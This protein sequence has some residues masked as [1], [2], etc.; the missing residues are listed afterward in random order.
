MEQKHRTS[1]TLSTSPR[2]LTLPGKILAVC[3][4]ILPF[5]TRSLTVEIPQA[6]RSAYFLGDG[7]YSDFE[8]L[9]REFFLL[10]I[11]AAGVIWFFYEQIA[12]RP[13]RK[14][15]MTR[16]TAV[17]FILLGL[18]L[19]LGLLST[20][21]SEYATESWLGIYMLYE[22]YLALVGY[23]VVFTA[24]WYW[25]DRKEVL[26]FVKS[27]LTVLSIVLGVL[28][29]L[30]R[31]GICYY[32]SAI[33]QFLGGLQGT[34]GV[35][36]AVSLTFGN[37][38]YLG[39]YCAMLLPVV[40]SLITREGTTKRLLVQI[41]AA[42][43]LATALLLSKVMNA[44]LL[45]FGLTVVFLLIWAF[46]TNW[47][48][49]V[50][51]CLC[52]V[53]AAAVVFGSVGFLWS[54]NGD[55]LSEKF[56]H[57]MIGMAQEETFR[58]LSIDLNGNTVSVKNANT[59]FSVATAGNNLT[60]QE[61]T[62]T[63]NGTEVT[64]QIDADGMTCS[65]AEPELKHCQVQVQSDRLDFLMGY[66]T[67]LEVVRQDGSWLAMG[68]GQTPLTEVPEVSSSKSLQQCYPYLNGRVFVW[69]NTISALRDCWIL[70]HGPATTIFYLNQYDLPALLNIFGVYALYNKPHNWYLQVAQDTGIPS[71]LLIL[72]V[73]VLFFVCGF[74]KC[75]RKQE[76]WD[77]FRTGLLLSVLSYA[78]M[79]FFNDSLIYHAPMFWF[80]L[81]IGWRQMTVGTE[82]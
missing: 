39:M 50:K 21:T 19:L 64:P 46:H 33:V 44:I 31:S 71:M 28:A 54:R 77:A 47:K 79:A 14:L 40:V 80:L 67:P 16:L 43:L 3:L 9:F 20:I 22:G 10:G 45:G 52:G 55:T 36:D 61:L 38:D 24:A 63:C 74:R 2:K 72:G 23:V 1:V 49:L 37:A 41:L 73:L 69:A 57:T 76:K 62:F 48:P 12:L 60:P 68:V 17:V 4:C 6:V 15:P 25:I 65:F 53:T 75:F 56:R 51:G 34:V 35:G 78:L 26:D 82:E 70:G 27:C 81:G 29:L 30:E 18:Y 42:V 5:L 66:A 8:Q 58:I 13:K 11:A 59:T 7:G 32:N